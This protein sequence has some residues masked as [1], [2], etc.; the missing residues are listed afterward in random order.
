MKVSTKIT[1][2]L[3]SMTEKTRAPRE[4]WK[5]RHKG[6]TKKKKTHTHTESRSRP[7]VHKTTKRYNI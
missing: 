2:W 6:R 1:R 5:A 7:G 3:R 4:R